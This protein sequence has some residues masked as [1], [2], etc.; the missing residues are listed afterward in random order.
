MSRKGQ[1]GM[2]PLISSGGRFESEC[3]TAGCTAGSN[4]RSAAGKTE[5]DAVDCRWALIPERA[6][7]PSRNPSARRSPYGTVEGASGIALEGTESV[8]QK[9]VKQ[10]GDLMRNPSSLVGRRVID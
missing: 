1:I 8:P 6:G 2:Q 5:A 7:E 4:L 10:A 3:S 9:M